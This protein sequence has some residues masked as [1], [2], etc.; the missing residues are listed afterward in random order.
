M[1]IVVVVHRLKNFDE[2][3]K[4]FKADFHQKL[5]VGDFS[6][7]AMTATEFTLSGKW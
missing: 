2:W 4:L 7:E 5:V 3:L 6:A 1:P